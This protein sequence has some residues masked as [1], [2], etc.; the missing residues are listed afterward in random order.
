MRVY[1]IIDM[2]MIILIFTKN[3]LFN[4]FKNKFIK[5]TKF[6]VSPTTPKL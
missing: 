3:T 2:C 4:I 5:I 6:D 1:N